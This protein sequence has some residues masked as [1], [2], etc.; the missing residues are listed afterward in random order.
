MAQDNSIPKVADRRLI[1]VAHQYQLAGVHLW[2]IVCSPDTNEYLGF[3]A[4]HGINQ[5]SSDQ[6]PAVPPAN[7]SA[8][9]SALRS[10]LVMMPIADASKAAQSASMNQ[11]TEVIATVDHYAQIEIIQQAAAAQRT[12]VKTM[13]AINAGANFFGCRP[14]TDTLQLAKV[15][16]QQP[17]LSFAGLT[18]EIPADRT[19]NDISREDSA[20][21]ALLDT[22]LKIQQKGI[23]CPLMHL[24]THAFISPSRVPTGWHVSLPLNAISQQTKAST[25]THFSTTKTQASQPYIAMIV[26]RPSLEA[27]II[28]LGTSF[29][30]HASNIILSTGD[31]L[32]IKQID[33]FRCVLDMTNAKTELCIGQSIHFSI[34][35]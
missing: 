34:E 28:D 20:I 1:D 27:A 9:Q 35:Y 5:F 32:P 30:Q 6:V 13:V 19:L 7:S 33:D 12:T 8:S 4:R 18:T 24:R 15:I 26:A 29:M 10:I 2:P 21:S 17:D 31:H 22:A 16:H 11:T 25:V 14:G 23:E 3:F